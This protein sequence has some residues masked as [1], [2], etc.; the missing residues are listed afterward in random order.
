M[1]RTLRIGLVGAGPAGQAHAF[2]YTNAR[3]ADELGEVEIV[4]ET[5]V[6][7]NIALA[8]TVARRYGFKRAVRSVDEMLAEGI[9]AVSVA[10]PN[11]LSSP[12]LSQLL[13]AGVHVLAEKP[14][15]KSADEALEL[16]RLAD[17]AGVVA[18]VGFSYRRI[19]ALAAAAR[20]IRDGAIGTPYFATAK[21]LADYAVDADGPLN[22][23]FVKATAGAGTLMDMGTHALDALE[24][25]VGP[26]DEVTSAVLNTS[27]TERPDPS[28]GRGEVDTDD[29]ALVTLRFDGGAVGTMLASRVAAGVPIEFDLEVFGSAGHLRFSYTDLNAYSIYQPGGG[30]DGDGVR[31]V[32][33]GPGSPHFEDV[34]PMCFK[35]NPTGYGEAFIAEV[36]DFLKAISG[37]TP[38]D[39]DFAAAA[40]TMQAAQAAIE[41]STTGK[42]VSISHQ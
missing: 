25:L 5:V 26:I 42:P 14:L 31:R 12:V 33:S 9:D 37:V 3:M 10:L 40:R 2:G 27:I 30:R 41:S 38:M 22:W 24:F 18:G 17:T 28:G 7:P 13:R 39:T 34:M 21:F 6:D 19:P 23:R 1:T 36:Q 20:A 4:L 35:G 15:G 29:T 11:H 8:T 16:T 32:I